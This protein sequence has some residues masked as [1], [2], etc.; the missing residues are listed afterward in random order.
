MTTDPVTK[1]HAPRE[2]EEEEVEEE[3]GDQALSM[4]QLASVAG[5]ADTGGNVQSWPACDD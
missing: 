3:T 5:G 1:A 4:D 2:V